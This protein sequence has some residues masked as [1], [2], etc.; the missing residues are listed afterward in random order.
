MFSEE[1]KKK[2]GTVHHPPTKT[3]FTDKIILFKPSS[4]GF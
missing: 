3:N 2:K 4:D 1:E